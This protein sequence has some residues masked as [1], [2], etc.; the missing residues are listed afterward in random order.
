MSP[1]TI[2]IAISSPVLALL[3]IDAQGI[4]RLSELNSAIES[5]I[6]D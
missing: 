3:P 6:D 4:N 2:P 1:L 5:R